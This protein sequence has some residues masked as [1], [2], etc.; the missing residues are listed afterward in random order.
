MFTSTNIWYDKFMLSN[1]DDTRT[2]SVSRC[3]LFTDTSQPQTDELA[4]LD[5]DD[6]MDPDDPEDETQGM[7]IPAG[8]RLQEFTPAA[9]DRLLLQRGVLVRL[10]MGW[11][12]GLIIQQSPQRHLY[13][14]CVQLEVDHSTRK[15]KLPLEKYS[16][17]P[18]AAVGSW[19]LL[20]S[21]SMAGRVRTP[22]VTLVDQDG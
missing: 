18:D 16:G 20:E 9:L 8:F 11:F 21:V 19:V 17:D 22:K 6:S 2:S 5:E 3:P 15:M 4:L 7:E 1:S 12:G 14:Y 10:G 13:D